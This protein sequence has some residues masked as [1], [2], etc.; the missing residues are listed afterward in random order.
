MILNSENSFFRRD[1]KTA[2]SSFSIKL[3]KTRTGPVKTYNLKRSYF[4]KGSPSFID[5]LDR[6]II[7]VYNRCIARYKAIEAAINADRYFFQEK[8]ARAMNDKSIITPETIKE[9]SEA[10][11]AIA[12]SKEKELSPGT[13]NAYRIDLTVLEKF[14]DGEPVTR[15]KMKSYREY[16]EAHYKPE[17]TNHKI[18]TAN[19][20]LRWAGIDATIQNIRLVRNATFEN[21]MTPADLRRMLR[22]ADKLGD[23]RTKAIM[24]TLVGTGIRIGELKFFTVEA[25]KEKHV[26]VDNKGSR[27]N[28]AMPKQ[29]VQLLKRYCKAAGITSGVIFRTKRGKPITNSQLWVSLKRIAGAARVKKSKIHAH[30]F[31][32]LFAINYLNRGG[33]IL[34]L[35]EILGHKSL[36]TTT[37]YTRTTTKELRRKMSETCILDDM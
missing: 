31:R 12:A 5:K 30:S 22:Y 35:K 34:D 1:S 4:F 10:R 24:E 20:Y 8:G 25:V 9:F 19:M 15:E 16:L 37:I 32:H 21:V 29:V 2:A 13:I 14:L 36:E 7:L 3:S 28:I 11:I 26:I 33:N 17:T 27:R 18:R 23:I 6:F